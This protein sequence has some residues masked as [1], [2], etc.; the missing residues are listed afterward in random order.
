[1]SLSAQQVLLQQREPPPGQQLIATRSHQASKSRSSDTVLP[2]KAQSSFTSDLELSAP[3][4]SRHLTSER[5]RSCSRHIVNA[6]S[7]EVLRKDRSLG[8]KLGLA[9]GTHKLDFSSC[10]LREIPEEVF[11][12]EE[13]EV[14]S[15]PGAPARESTVTGSVSRS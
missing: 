7:S 5:A 6:L 9:K 11:D 13:L 14:I 10:E 2:K 8:V 3:L 15:T 1:M 12:L 4:H